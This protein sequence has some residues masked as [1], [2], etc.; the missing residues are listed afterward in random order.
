MF[1]KS[2]TSKPSLTYLGDYPKL[3]VSHLAYNKMR[4]YIDICDKEIGWLGVAVRNEVNPTIIHLSDVFLFHQEVNSTTC[5]ITEEGLAKFV[6][7]VFENYS[8]EQAMFICNNLKVWGHSHVNMGVTPS[9]QDDTQINLFRQNEAQ[10][11]IR[12][13][14][15]KRGEINITFYDFVNCVKVSNMEWDLHVEGNVDLYDN[16]KKEIEEKV[17]VK[18]YWSG[19]N[20]YNGNKR[21]QNNYSYIPKNN[22]TFVQE[23]KTGQ[24]FE[25]KKKEE[26][27]KEETKITYLTEYNYTPIKEE[28]KN[29]NYIID[30]GLDGYFND[31]NSVKTYLSE[32]E[33]VVI[34]NSFEDEAIQILELYPDFEIFSKKELRNVHSICSNYLFD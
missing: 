27:K 1:F 18:T 5:E 2:S 4:Y 29:N 3:Y 31:I 24:Y 19:Y 9:G 28:K 23:T 16:I 25:S 30:M 6:G 32:D 34:G 22:T 12:I 7:Y 8:D 15:N 14:G 33:I 13:I 20:N 21:Y 10:W 11:F 26:T 17:K